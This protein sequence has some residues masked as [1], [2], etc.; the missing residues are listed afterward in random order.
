MGLECCHKLIP[1]ELCIGREQCFMIN[2]PYLCWASQLLRYKGSLVH[3]CA[4]EDAELVLDG[5]NPIIC[6]KWI[7]CLVEQRWLR[8][9]KTDVVS[10]CWW[11]LSTSAGIVLHQLPH[12]FG[13]L[14]AVS[15]KGRNSLSQ[16]GRWWWWCSVIS[17]S[18]VSSVVIAHL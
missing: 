1:S 6:L 9:Q 17:I 18:M 4:I 16:G 2:P 12:Q 5:A 15:D 13:L 14:I 8:G 7:I 3:F 10:F 11:C